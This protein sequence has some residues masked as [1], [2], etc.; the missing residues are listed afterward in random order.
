[1]RL[2]WDWLSVICGVKGGGKTYHWAVDV[3]AAHVVHFTAALYSSLVRSG[4]IV[5]VIHPVLSTASWITSILAYRCS[6]RNYPGMYNTALGGCSKTYRSRGQRQ[7]H[8]N[9]Q[10]QNW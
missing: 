2:P 3:Q 5:I 6:T 1:M 7:R 10:R 9:L 4:T 8:R